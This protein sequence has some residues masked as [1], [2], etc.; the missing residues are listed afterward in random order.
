[1][2]TWPWQRLKRLILVIL[3][4]LTLLLVLHSGRRVLPPYVAGLAAA[5][6]L[7]PVV[8]HIALGVIAVSRALRFPPLGRMARSLAVVLTYLLVAGMIA[9]VIAV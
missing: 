6:V 2:K 1:M 5:Y 9:G 3:T 7:V 8:N 4:A